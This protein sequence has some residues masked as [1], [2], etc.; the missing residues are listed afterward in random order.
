MRVFFGLKVRTSHKRGP[1]WLLGGL[2]HAT[3]FGVVDRIQVISVTVFGFYFDG[4]PAYFRKNIKGEE[5]K[6]KKQ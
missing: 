5:E 1:Q 6:E 2:Y 4:G 3:L